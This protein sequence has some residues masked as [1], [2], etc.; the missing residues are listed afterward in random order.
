MLRDAVGE[1]NIVAVRSWTSLQSPV[2]HMS[3]LLHKVGELF[4]VEFGNEQGYA[5]APHV[6]QL[7]AS[8]RLAQAGLRVGDSVLAING[9]LA[10]SAADAAEL[11][12]GCDSGTVSRAHMMAPFGFRPSLGI[13]GSWVVGVLCGV[14]VRDARCEMRGSTARC[15]LRP[16]V[17]RARCV[18]AVVGRRWC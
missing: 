4:R 15:E 8:S 5:M 6:I 9:E 14:H 16:G 2:R 17:V 11:L 1:V 13:V 7:Q 12:K 3:L 18:C 10:A